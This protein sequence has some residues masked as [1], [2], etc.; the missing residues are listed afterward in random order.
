MFIDTCI[1]DGKIERLK[2]DLEYES[3]AV[4]KVSFVTKVFREWLVVCKLLNWD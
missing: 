1:K 3:S 4:K 2:N